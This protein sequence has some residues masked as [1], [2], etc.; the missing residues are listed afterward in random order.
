MSA[1][2]FGRCVANDSRL[3]FDLRKGRGIKPG[4]ATKVRSY[5][6][7]ENTW[8]PM[9]KSKIWDDAKDTALWEAVSQGKRRRHIAA[10]MGLSTIAVDNRISRLADERLPF[11]PHGMRLVDAI[12]LEAQGGGL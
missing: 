6:S 10:E 9:P 3:V 11:R 12:R 4:I 8:Q 7:A 1:S 5:M 2:R